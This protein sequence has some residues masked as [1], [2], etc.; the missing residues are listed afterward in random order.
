[1]RG[2]NVAKH[3][4][5]LA[6]QSEAVTL[7][8]RGVALKDVAPMIGYSRHALRRWYVRCPDYA[9]RVDVARREAWRDKW[10]MV[11]YYLRFN[12]LLDACEMAGV[13][14][15]SWHTAKRHSVYGPWL[16]RRIARMKWA[17]T[18]ARS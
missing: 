8:R 13:S 14:V 4:A 18:M 9:E 16:H 6:A 1:M 11:V 12:N 5:M 17:R 7:F 15:Q 3:E 10:G 2:C